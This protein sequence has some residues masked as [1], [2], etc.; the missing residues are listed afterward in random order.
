MVETENTNMMTQADIHPGNGPDRSG[1]RPSLDL[2]IPVYNEEAVL[3]RLL[4]ELREVFDDRRCREA[5]LAQCR[6][7]F[8]DDGSTDQSAML[9]AASIRTGTM[10]GELV[11]LSR[12]FGHQSAITAG[13][14]RSRAD[15]AAIIDAD[16][17]DP[18]EVIYSMLGQWRQG[19]DVVYGV[20]RKRKESWFKRLCYWSY[21]R[22]LAFLSETEV[23]LDSGDFCLM[24]R[25]IVG[26]LNALP[27]KLRFPRGLRSWVGF[28]QAG[29]EY[30][31]RARQAGEV[32]YTV[33]KLYNLATH[34]IAAMS[35][36]PLRLAQFLSFIC[37]LLALA[38]FFLSLG[39]YLAYSSEAEL[40]LWFLMTY[41]LISLIAALL[42]GVLY[43]LGA[44]IGRMYLEVK[45]RPNYIVREIIT[46][47]GTLRQD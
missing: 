30:E 45:G 29:L 44:Y 1:L 46:P 42:F 9:L 5:G 25:R 7:I 3:P 10:P 18:P 22:L 17:Q 35:I 32:K 37:A 2:I 20:R 36:R 16:L 28:H 39:K 40:A 14:A 27:E 31:R 6:F 43:I 38:F 24:D 11:C 33:R 21:Y 4:D 23:P 8:V 13:L 26:T 15:L 19:I 41:M 34:G 12:N 47:D